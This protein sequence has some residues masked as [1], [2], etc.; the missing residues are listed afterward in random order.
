MLFR[1]FLFLHRFRI[2]VRL[3]RSLF[4]NSAFLFHLIDKC[5]NVLH[6]P[7]HVARQIADLVFRRRLDLSRKI[8]VGHRVR[9]GAKF[10]HRFRD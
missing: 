4:R 6:H 2:L 1:S 9:Q 8:A 7:V 5:A 3:L 10:Y